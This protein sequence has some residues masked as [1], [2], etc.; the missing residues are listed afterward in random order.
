MDLQAELAAQRERLRACEGNSAELEELLE[1]QKEATAV[2]ASA[3][4]SVSELAAELAKQRDE[5]KEAHEARV[6]KLQA[7]IRDLEM[8]LEISKECLKGDPNKTLDTDAEASIIS[9]RHSP[10]RIQDDMFKLGRPMMLNQIPAEIQRGI[11]V[12]KS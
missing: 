9:I 3:M 8:M 4:E 6:K 7:R 2:E 1:R 10:A 5:A 11:Q 12:S